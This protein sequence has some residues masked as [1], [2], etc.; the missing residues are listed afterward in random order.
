MRKTEVVTPKIPHI[1]R[2]TFIKTKKIEVPTLN[3]KGE[4]KTIFFNKN[5]INIY[6]VDD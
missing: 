4:R 1:Q 3:F 6:S 5:S 2:T